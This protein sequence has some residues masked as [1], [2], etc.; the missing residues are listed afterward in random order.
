M[1]RFV[2]CLLLML[3]VSGV[4]GTPVTW[5][6]AGGDR[7]VAFINVTVIPMD[8]ERVLPGHTVLVRGD[9]IVQVG[10]AAA[11]TVPAQALQVDGAG[12]Y[13]MPGLAEMHAHI[14]S[15][16]APQEFTDAVLFLYVAN[17]VTTARG[18]LGAPNQFALR[19]KAQRG[20]IVSPTL[21]LA[22][23]SFS[24]RS[25]KSP[26]EAIQKVRQQKHEGWDLLKIPSGPH[27]REAYDAM[28][29]T[30]QE[31]GLR[32]V[33]HVPAEVGLQHAL[34]MGQ[35]TIDHVDGYVEYLQAENDPVDEAKLADIVQ[36]TKQAGTWIVPTMAVWEVL[37]GARDLETL[38]S[39]AEVK[40]R[41][42][43]SR[44]RLGRA[45]TTPA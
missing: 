27:T 37:L 10:P 8:A 7:E 40:Y 22:G 21:Y 1:K 3:L 35:E 28:A 39:Y 44:S 14:P 31:V 12:K 13:L 41:C 11:V 25:I 29:T 17:G 26:D 16:E 43:R 38:L 19:E 15:Q 24:G 9:R 18:M 42:P 34:E 45:R 6:Q 30:A 32:F 23:P 36:R 5:P 4:A 20:E 33:G 2:N